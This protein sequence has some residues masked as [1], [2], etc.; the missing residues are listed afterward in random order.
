MKKFYLTSEEKTRL[1]VMHASQNNGK[2]RDRLKAI[3]LRSE[4]WTVPKISQALRLHQSTIIRHI[5]DYQ[6]FWSFSPSSHE[7]P[8]SMGQLVDANSTM[9]DK[10]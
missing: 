9:L 1:E 2:A 10:A 5:Q 6:C 8:E 7:L 4:G 3:L